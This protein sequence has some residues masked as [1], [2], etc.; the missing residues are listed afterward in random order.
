MER[1]FPGIV[2][3]HVAHHGK[4]GFKIWKSGTG[5][6]VGHVEI[7]ALCKEIEIATRI[8]LRKAVA[9]LPHPV[10]KA[11]GIRNDRLW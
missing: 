7:G 1:L 9:D 2:V 10:Q 11:N 6:G 4:Q 5:D 8:I 3:L